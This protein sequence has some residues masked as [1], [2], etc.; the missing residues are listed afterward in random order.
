MGNGEYKVVLAGRKG[1]AFCL[2]QCLIFLFDL[3]HFKHVLLLNLL[4]T[5]SDDHHIGIAGVH[6]VKSVHHH[7]ECIIFKHE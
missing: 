2:R 4:Q 3:L 7:C 1:L 5:V 6:L